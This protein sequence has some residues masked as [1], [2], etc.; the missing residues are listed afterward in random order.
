MPVEAEPAAETGGLS[1]EDYL[2]LRK[3]L[4]SEGLARTSSARERA[5]ARALT[6]EAGRLDT[7]TALDARELAAVRAKI[8]DARAGILNV[9]AAIEAGRAVVL[10][11]DLHVKDP[12]LDEAWL[13]CLSDPAPVSA[14]AHAHA[15]L[16]LDQ[17][18]DEALAMVCRHLDLRDLGRLACVSSLFTEPTLPG[19]AGASGGSGGGGESGA[20]KLSVIDEGARLKLAM[21]TPPP[22]PEWARDSMIVARRAGETWVRTLWRLRY[23]S[24]FI[25][26]TPAMTL[27]EDGASARHLGL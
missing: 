25:Q 26:Y 11:A 10:E 5:A 23:R 9:R 18:S 4:S 19:P 1:D 3:A 12:P 21:S 20:K 16:K 27:S 14:A 17:L 15:P 8:R 6:A 22:L 7:Q 24:A 2:A 13:I